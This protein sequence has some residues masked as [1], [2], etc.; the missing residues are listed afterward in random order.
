MPNTVFGSG[1]IW[2]TP[3]TDATGAAISNPTP[4]MVGIMQDASIDISFDTKMLH[5]SGQ[6]AIAAGRGKGKITGKAKFAQL[7]GALINSLF[8]G[9]TVTTGLLADFNDLTG[10]TI[11]TTPAI[12]T[13][14]PPNSGTF[15][16]DL[17]VRNASGTPMTRV[18]SGPATGQYACDPSSGQYTFAVADSG[19]IVYICYQYTATSTVAKKSAVSNLQMGPAPTFRCD[20]FN[21]FG[22]S[23]KLTLSLY[24]CISNKLSLSTKMDDFTI[25]EFDFEAYA[26]SIGRVLQWGTAE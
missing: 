26:D 22:P 20:F 23:N 3:L 11:P 2:G 6:F 4:I 19:Q 8:F 13:V 15:A 21:S 18:A 25:P 16:V 10:T 7:N 5:G 1:V 12:L 14:T 24:S 9:Q 17:G